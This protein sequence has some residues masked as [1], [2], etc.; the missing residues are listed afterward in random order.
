MLIIRGDALPVA[1]R[2][3]LLLVGSAVARY[4]LLQ[5]NIPCQIVVPLTCM[6]KIN[7]VLLY[8]QGTK[9]MRG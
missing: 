6:F 8:H 2:Q 3:L 7:A 1:R 4:T 5:A 9:I